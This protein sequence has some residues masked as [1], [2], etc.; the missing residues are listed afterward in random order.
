ML[1]LDD[2]LKES[3]RRKLM[4]ERG[5]FKN[6]TSKEMNDMILKAK[7]DIKDPV[8]AKAWSDLRERKP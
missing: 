7:V 6:D 1:P 2:A 3:I 8:F 5:T 4:L